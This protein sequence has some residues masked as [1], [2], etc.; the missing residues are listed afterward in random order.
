MPAPLGNQPY[1]Q[2]GN[3]HPGMSG[4]PP[5]I[6]AVHT[7]HSGPP[8]P[9]LYQPLM[10]MGYPQQQS[11]DGFPRP[12]PESPSSPRHAV[13]PSSASM[14]PPPPTGPPRSP[15]LTRHADHVDSPTAARTSP[16][17]LSSITSPYPNPGTHFPDQHHH[18]SQ[19]KNCHAQTLILGER[20]RL[21]INRE[22]P[23]ALIIAENLLILLLAPFQLIIKTS[24]CHSLFHLPLTTELLTRGASVIRF[25]CPL[26]S[27][28][29]VTV[30]RGIR[31][32]E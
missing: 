12:K 14:L 3:M 16:L 25:I 22:G 5:P 15:I 18:Q 4:A 24:Q 19:S 11:P 8:G 23:V 9:I 2:M 6:E 17:A 30:L 28:I 26:P 32:T 27:L 29:E 10:P 31:I 1:Y 20:L 13:G 7:Y 21:E